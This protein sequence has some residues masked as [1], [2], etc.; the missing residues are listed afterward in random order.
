MVKDGSLKASQWLR[1]NEIWMKCPR[2]I[3]L[4]VNRSSVNFYQKDQKYIGFLLRTCITS[5]LQNCQPYREGLPNTCNKVSESFSRFRCTQINVCRYYCSS[6][7]KCVP[8]NTLWIWQ[9]LLTPIDLSCLSL[10]GSSSYS[11][12]LHIL[13]TSHT[14]SISAPP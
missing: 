14:N 2:Q 10:S 1:V 7:A 9:R 5:D 13:R 4:Q 11:M 3:I 6:H 8:R 12:P